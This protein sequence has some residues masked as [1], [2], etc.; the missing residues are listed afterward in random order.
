[1]VSSLSKDFWTIF[2]L[3]NEVIRRINFLIVFVLT[4]ACC[5][6]IYAFRAFEISAPRL[7]NRLP[8]SVKD[9][10]SVEVFKRRLKTHLFGDCYTQ[11]MY[12]SDYYKL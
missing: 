9:S 4:D 5:P 11:E 12:I 10:C 2:I 7:Y 8:L 1:M 3:S 6:L